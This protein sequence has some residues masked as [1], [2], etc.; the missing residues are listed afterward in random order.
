MALE[1]QNVAELN[2]TGFGVKQTRVKSHPYLIR[3]E[4]NSFL[5]IY[6]SFNVYDFFFACEVLCAPYM[7]AMPMKARK[8]HW[9]PWDWHYRQPLDA[10]SQTQ[11]LWKST[12]GS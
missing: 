4:V 1:S 6:F 7:Y 2:D 12:Q 10:G 9:I 3:L 11:D 8:A 5:L